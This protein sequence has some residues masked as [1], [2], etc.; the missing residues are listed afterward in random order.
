MKLQAKIRVAQSAKPIDELFHSLFGQYPEVEVPEDIAIA[1]DFKDSLNELLIYAEMQDIDVYCFNQHNEFIIKDLVEFQNALDYFTAVNDPQSEGLPVPGNYWAISNDPFSFGGVNPYDIDETYLPSNIRAPYDNDGRSIIDYYETQVQ[2]GEPSP[3]VELP[4]S[5]FDE[6]HQ[7]MNLTI[8]SMLSKYGESFP[9]LNEDGTLSESALRDLEDLMLSEATDNQLFAFISDGIDAVNKVGGLFKDVADKTGISK[10]LAKVRDTAGKVVSKTAEK[11][12]DV[13]DKGVETAGKAIKGAI[14]KHKA[15]KAKDK[16]LRKQDIMEILDRA[17]DELD[18]LKPKK[19]AQ[20]K[21]K[22]K[23]TEDSSVLKDYAKAKSQANNAVRTA[24]E[25][26]MNGDAKDVKS[27]QVAVNNKVN[28]E[29]KAISA[30]SKAKD[31]AK[32]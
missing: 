11:T 17:Q 30:K 22:G 27:K 16:E 4:A 15:N 14:D 8:Q 20:E 21:A 3:K 28:D 12:A 29:L 19:I 23:T 1:Q 6:K 7:M 13:V 26:N 24:I 25:N 18:A 32:K 9:F 5:N 10:G 31:E 2:D